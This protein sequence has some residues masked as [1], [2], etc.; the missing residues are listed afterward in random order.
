MLNKTATWNDMKFLR[1]KSVLTAT[2][3]SMNAQHQANHV[4]LVAVCFKA[5]PTERSRIRESNESA[6]VCVCFR[7]LGRSSPRL[8]NVFHSGAQ[9]SRP[10]HM[11]CL[12]MRPVRRH[13]SDSVVFTTTA[14][15]SRDRPHITKNHCG[16]LLDVVVIQF[17]PRPNLHALLA[18]HL[19]WN[20]TF[21]LQAAV[22]P[23]AHR[24]E[25]TAS[26]TSAESKSG[27]GSFAG[28]SAE[29]TDTASAVRRGPAKKLLTRAA[30]ETAKS[31]AKVAF[32]VPSPDER[33][34]LTM[35]LLSLCS[36][37]RFCVAP[38]NRSQ[39]HC[40]LRPWSQPCQEML[41]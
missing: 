21:F 12:S 8:K 23:R 14:S 16:L 5:L 34:E 36:W 10:H 22:T 25:H 17:S 32:E 20:L 4:V 41:P 3:A 9:N 6:G 13:L 35:C 28:Q 31:G 15:K 39:L 40:T 2:Y 1:S 19:V 29:D 11:L 18:K 30:S 33:Q 38:L 27:T 37:Q 7:A 24:A 26:T